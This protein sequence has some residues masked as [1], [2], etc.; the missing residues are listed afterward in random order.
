[1]ISWLVQRGYFRNYPENIAKG[2]D[3]ILRFDYMGSS[4]FEFGALGQSLHRIRSVKDVYQFYN[5]KVPTNK[6]LEKKIMIY[7]KSQDFEDVKNN[8]LRFAKNE[9][10]TKEWV[11]F[12]RWLNTGDQTP[13]FWWD[14]DNDFMWWKYNESFTNSFKGLI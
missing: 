10:R 11:G 7:C 5:I 9:I 6:I 13:D 4:E 12:E 2:I 3:L 1:M 14:I 8:I